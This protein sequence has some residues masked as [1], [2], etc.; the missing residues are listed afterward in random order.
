MSKFTDAPFE[1]VTKPEAAKR[2][3][4]TAIRLC[5]AG[6]DA[7]SI[8][9]LACAAHEILTVL[10]ATKGGRS[11]ILDNPLYSAD[12]K[13]GVRRGF[14]GTYNF[15]KHADRDAGALLRFRPLLVEWI[16][17]DAVV[18][19]RRATGH[20]FPEAAVYMLYFFTTY[21]SE[22]GDLPLAVEMRKQVAEMGESPRTRE[23]FHLILLREQPND[24]VDP[25]GPKGK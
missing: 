25:R 24:T 14:K 11:L 22:F 23:D 20:S 6:G 15:F 18:M 19:Y 16:I 3:L 8:R 1:I 5:L 2:Q 17:A 12:K 4:A 7:V 21:E 9:T 13:K 10:V